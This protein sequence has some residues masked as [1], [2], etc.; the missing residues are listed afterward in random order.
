MCS[1]T[2]TYRTKNYIAFDGD[3]SYMSY[4]NLL[5]WNADNKCEFTINNAHNINYANDDSLPESIKKQL[6]ARLDSSKNMVLIIDKAIKY[7]RKGIVKYE[8]NYALRNK[9]PII[10]V[11]KGYSSTDTNND[12]LWNDK[13][14]PLIPQCL[15]NEPEYNIYCLISP[16]TINVINS[17]IKYTKN[18]LPQAGFNWLWR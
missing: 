9:L 6:K 8:I 14:K 13:L 7:N 18:N 5:R 4:L 17:A 12:K 16:F 15:L 3:E 11:F 2:I 10:L 1:P